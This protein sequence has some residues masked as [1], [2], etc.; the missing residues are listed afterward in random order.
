[1]MVTKG[2][3]FTQRRELYLGLASELLS[4]HLHTDIQFSVRLGS[5]IRQALESNDFEK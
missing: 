4:Q 3:T 5:K 2:Q 1:M